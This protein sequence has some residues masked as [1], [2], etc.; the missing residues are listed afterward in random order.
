MSANQADYPIKAMAQEL[1]VSASGYYAWRSRPPSARA[2][3][4]QDLL[5]RIRTI[6]ATSRGT[7]GAPRVHAELEAEGVA[8]AKKRVARLMHVAQITGVSR[9]RSGPCASSSACWSVT[10]TAQPERG[11]EVNRQSI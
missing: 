11:T 7:Y 1:H 2:T 5:R 9:R 4:D 8:I 10:T 6:H 3:S